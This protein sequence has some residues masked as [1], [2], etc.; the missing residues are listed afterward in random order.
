MQWLYKK[1]KK[2]VSQTAQLVTSSSKKKTKWHTLLL[3]STC[4]HLPISVSEMFQ[5]SEGAPRKTNKQK[6]T[7]VYPF[8]I[9]VFIT[10]KSLLEATI[11]QFNSPCAQEKR[12]PYA[13][14][15]EF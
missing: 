14:R 1:K 6:N 7:T 11:L 5:Y 12:Q 3:I 2:K 15:T 13:G 10:G 4:I 9:T 8:K